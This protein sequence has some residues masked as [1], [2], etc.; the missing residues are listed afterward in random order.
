MDQAKSLGVTGFVKNSSDGTVCVTGILCGNSADNAQ[1]TGEAQGDQSS[2]DKFVQ[3]L[4]MGPSAA[5]VSKVDQK[6]ISPKE[7]ESGFSQ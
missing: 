2:L 1:V 4:N 7:G 5:K 6:E 3:H